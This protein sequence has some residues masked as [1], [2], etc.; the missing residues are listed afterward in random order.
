MSNMKSISGEIIE[1]VPYL[2]APVYYPSRGF[3]IGWWSLAH[4]APP[5]TAMPH[6]MPEMLVN[7]VSEY[8]LV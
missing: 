4:V 5:T 8:S 3:L 6:Y 2:L 7:S 1:T